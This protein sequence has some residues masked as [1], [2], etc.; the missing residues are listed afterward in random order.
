MAGISP[1]ALTTAKPMRWVK[2]TLPPRERARWL[3][4]TMRLSTSSLAGTARTLVAVGT[5]SEAS[6]LVTTRALAPRMGELSGWLTA[7][8]DFAA[9]GSRVLGAWL[10]DAV[11]AGADF[12]A[13]ARRADALAGAAFAGWALAG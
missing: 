8:S 7:P 5:A 13:S 3:L 10:D 4:M 9:P 2:L 1:S 12:L 11:G 6:M